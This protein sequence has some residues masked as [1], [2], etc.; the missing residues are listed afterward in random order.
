[1]GT[2]AWIVVLLLCAADVLEGTLVAKMVA[3]DA[4]AQAAMAERE[5]PRPDLPE[6]AP[7]PQAGLA[8]ARACGWD[9]VS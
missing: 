6:A 8:Q 2:R 3:L 9:C 7:T 5:P 4:R 1:M